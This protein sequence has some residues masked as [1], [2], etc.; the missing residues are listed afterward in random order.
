MTWIQLTRKGNFLHH[1][2]SRKLPSSKEINLPVSRPGGS[3]SESEG[4]CKLVLDSGCHRCHIVEEAVRPPTGD[5]EAQ[6]VGTSSFKLVMLCLDRP[7][8]V[9][10]CSDIETPMTFASHGLERMESEMR[11]FRVSLAFIFDLGDVL[12]PPLHSDHR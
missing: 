7:F 12:P 3:N 11:I 4:V 5:D 8:P 9:A 1:S 2:V 6:K 10:R